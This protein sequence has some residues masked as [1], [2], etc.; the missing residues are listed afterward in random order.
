MLHLC[1]AKPGAQSRKQLAL[2]SSAK[3]ILPKKALTPQ[4]GRNYHLVR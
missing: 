3:K 1:V 2:Y 4:T